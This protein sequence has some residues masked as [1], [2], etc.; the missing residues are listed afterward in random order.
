EN[1]ASLVHEL[2]KRHAEECDSAIAKELLANWHAAIARFT[3][4]V[5]TQYLAMTKVMDQAQ[6]D[7]VDFNEPGAWEN[8][9]ERVMEGAH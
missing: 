1:H 4:V 8:V 3:H 6:R 7:N 9:Y 5:P 2:V